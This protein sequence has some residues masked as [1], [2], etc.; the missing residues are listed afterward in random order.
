MQ[1]LS[2][3][4]RGEAQTAWSVA[5]S[6]GTKGAKR[7]VKMD[8]PHVFPFRASLLSSARPQANLHS[9]RLFCHLTPLGHI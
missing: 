3:L 2:G 8:R 4:V 1:R 6:L 7:M 5:R 9:T